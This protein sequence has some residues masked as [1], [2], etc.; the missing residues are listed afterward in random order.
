MP[1]PRRPR[2]APPVRALHLGLGNFF[3]AHQAWYTQHADQDWGIAAFTGRSA[4]VAQA[5]RAQD[6]RYTLD[7]RSADGDHF[8]MIDA[9]VKAHPGDDDPAWLTYWADPDVA[10]VTMTVTEAGYRLSDGRLDVVDPQVAAD[11]A[12]LRDSGGATTAPGRL[13]AGIRERRRVGAGPITVVPCDNLPRNGGALREALLAMAALVEPGL[14]EW[15]ATE[16]GFVSTAVDRITPATTEQ[17]RARLLRETGF[18]DAVP[19]VTEPFCEWVLAGEFLSD[20][21]PWQNGGAVFTDDV[22]PYEARKLLLLN[23]AH[24]MLAYAGLLRGHSL[25]SEAIADP[26]CRELVQRWWDDA[27]PLV[28]MQTDEY[29]Q[30]L[31]E[32]WANPGIAHLLS[33]IAMDGSQKLAIRVPP[34]VRS[35]RRAGRIP[36]AACTL[37][38]AWILYVRSGPVDAQREALMRLADQPWRQAV[39]ALLGVLDEQLAHDEQFVA[40][41]IDRAHELG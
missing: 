23:G 39:P 10:I 15:I 13:I 33:Q 34:V 26:W 41:V 12:S 38:A 19:V 4:R 11:I 16:V 14:D 24:S 27:C 36:D 5:L 2:P 7:V 29:T 21:P 18:K 40:A 3:R 22:G 9:V 20:R 37:L 25:V 8:E 31:L 6:C 28:P 17:D 32:R 1:Y 35:E 30:T